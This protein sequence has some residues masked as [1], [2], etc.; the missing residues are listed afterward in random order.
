MILKKRTKPL[1]LQKLEAL[2][3]RIPPEHPKHSTVKE[4]LNRMQAG[5]KSEQSI[6]YPLS[7]LSPKNYF[8][9]HDIRFFDGSHFFQIDTLI[10]TKQYFLILE[11]RN[12][13]GTITF[14]C[15]SR[16]LVRQ[17]D[18]KEEAFTDPLIQ[19]GRQQYQLNKWLQ[20]HGV[21]SIYIEGLVIVAN[22]RTVINIP[23]QSCYSERVMP[24][25]VLPNRIQKLDEKY[26]TRR[27]SMKELKNISE[28]IVELHT[29]LDQEI[30][31]RFNILKSDYYQE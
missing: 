12:I 26:K 14:N 19:I 23:D 11:V 7:F 20:H 2:Y 3:R 5:F 15:A 28:K 24:S 31:D 30:L 6:D 18:G 17:I 8:I 22:E 21:S 4:S 25:P 29:E 10:L 1:Q 16:Q 13:S 27:R 9:I